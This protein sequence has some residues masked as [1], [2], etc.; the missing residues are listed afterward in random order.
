MQKYN[1]F[2]VRW[3]NFLI[4]GAGKSGTTFLHR[5]LATHPDIFMSGLK[6]PN[7]FAF[8]GIDMKL[9]G[10]NDRRYVS[11]SILGKLEYLKMFESAVE[12][13]IGESSP[14][15]LFDEGAADKIHQCLPDA[16]ILIILRNPVEMLFSAWKHLTRLEY[17]DRGF[18]KA[19]S[20]FDVK[21]QYSTGNYVE[22]VNYSTQVSRYSNR[23]SKDNVR[24]VFFECLQH[25]PKEVLASTLT[26]LS[27]DSGFDFANVSPI[28]R[29]P[30]NVGI[31]QHE[32]TACLELV[33]NQIEQ[34]ESEY[35]IDLSHWKEYRATPKNIESLSNFHL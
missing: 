26:W 25:D 1:P 29:D 18:L 16:K 32:F 3:P 8:S 27:V 23:F 33:L 19:L 21:N 10:T 30:E 13:I 12:T 15:Y 6:E 2:F 5:V 9:I 31:D 34:L 11:Q 7:Y 4:V 17:E 35:H 24:I 14:S 22:K 28:N 20:T